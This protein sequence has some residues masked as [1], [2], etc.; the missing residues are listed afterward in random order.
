MGNNA[1]GQGGTPGWGQQPQQPQQ[2][3]WGAPPPQ[4]PQQPGWGA[5][6]PQAPQ[7]PGWGAPPPQAPQQPGWGAPPPQAGWNPQPAKQGNGCLKGC[8]IVGGILVVLVVLLLIGIS[9]LGLKFADDM[10]VGANGEVKEC[11]FVSNADLEKVLG[12][13]ATALPIKGIA[14]ATIGIALD[15]R[16]LKDADNCLL[17]A[18]ASSSSS[19]SAL[20]RIAKTSGMDASSKFDSEKKA[21]S[22]AGYLGEDVSDLGDQAF[23]TTAGTGEADVYP[24]VGVL[25]RKG[26]DLVYV[27]MLAAP[28]SDG[29]L[30]SDCQLAQKVAKLVLK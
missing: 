24:G 7:Q 15:K 16:V 12:K 25:V 13:D 29:G 8:L 2:P 22:A 26:N 17:S 6:P 10:G 11:P 23:C 5:P 9:V 14:N 18:N 3:N 4:A 20:G 21:A 27:S 19:D 28:T 1:P 30:A